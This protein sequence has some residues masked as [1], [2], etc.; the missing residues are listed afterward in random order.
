MG[1]FRISALIDTGASSSLLRED[2]FMAM[3][4]RVRRVH[5]I[6]NTQPLQGIAGVRLP[7]TGCTEVKV[8]KVDSPLPVDIITNMGPE[9]IIGQNWL[10]R[11]KAV[12]DFPAKIVKWFNKEWP[13]LKSYQRGTAIC[14]TRLPCM[15]YPEGDRVIREYADVFSG[16]KDPNGECNLPPMR[17]K[18]VGEPIALPAYRTPLAKRRLVDEAIEEML[19]AGVIRPSSSPWAAPVTLVPKKDGT[20]RFCVDYRR[21]NEVTIKDQFPIP[22]IQ[23]IFDM[24]GGSKIFSSLDLK[25]GYW[26]V[27]VH[28]DD[29]EKSAF[30]CHRG[31]YEFNVMP[32]GLCNAPS[33]FSR[34]MDQALGELIGK[35]VLV[36]IDDLVIF[37]ENKI[38]HARDVGLVLEKLRQ[39]GLKLKPSKCDFAKEEIDLLGYKVG[40]NGISVNPEKVKAIKELE[41]PSAVRHVRSFLGM[42]NYYRQCIPNFAEVAQPLVALTKK[43]ARF[44]WG[45]SQEV[46]FNKLKDLLV[47]SHVMAAP[48]VGQE[49]FLHTDASD[50]TIGGIL[51]QTDDN[52]VERVI[53][54]ISHQLSGSQL[55]WPTIEKECYAIVYCIEKLRPYLYGAEFTVFTDHR[56]LLS[57]FTKQLQNTKIQRWGVLLAEYGAKIQYRQGKYHVRPDMLSR[58][59]HRNKNK[60]VAV[61][62]SDDWVDPQ[63]FPDSNVEEL[64]PLVHDG[65]DLAKVAVHQR[66]EYPDICEQ[67]EKDEGGWEII[68]GVVYSTTRPT[69]AAALYPRL[70]LPKEWQHRVIMRAH[71]DVGHMATGKT[72]ARIS[73]SYIWPGMRGDVKTTLLKCTVCQA[74]SE[75]KEHVPMGEMPI[76]TYPNQ[77]IGMDLI[78]L[79]R[80]P[81]GLK[82]ALTIIDHCSGWAEVYPLPN[83]TNE[84]VWS[85]WT[86][87]YLPAHSVPEVIITDRGQEFCAGPWE[88]YLSQLGVE[89]RKTTPMHPQSNGRTERFNKTFKQLLE[90][91]VN[92]QPTQ[93]PGKIG[94]C[95]TAYRHAVSN[96]TGYSPFYLMYGRHGR[97]PMTKT[98]KQGGGSKFGNR[99]D[100]LSTALQVASEM[101]KNSRIYNRER[102]RQK[103]NAN[104]IEVGDIVVLKADPRV[105]LTSR[106][107]PQWQVTRV[108]GLAIYVRNQLSG[109]CKVVNREKVKLVDPE[110]VWDE[111]NPRPKR[112]QRK[113]RPI[114][115]NTKDQLNQDDPDFTVIHQKDVAQQTLVQQRKITKRHAVPDSAVGDTGGPKRSKALEQ[116]TSADFKTG[117]KPSNEIGTQAHN[118]P[119]TNEYSQSTHHMRLRDCPSRKR[120]LI[121]SPEIQKR[122]RL[123]A[124]C[125][126][127]DFFRQ[128]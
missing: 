52:G 35:C 80:S 33:V 97:L 25:A 92:N 42:A 26:Q 121:P 116:T 11:G 70:L 5:Y 41:T 14:E 127:T 27:K 88:E 2:V 87:Y 17:I 74:H 123:E 99:L 91:A 40:V 64:L 43:H 37:S 96:T 21:L 82:Y 124:I 7:L 93:W 120:H 78:E 90:K 84:S 103:A 85:A 12:I 118:P 49:Y 51:C 56:P 16:E 8:D 47:S 15:G 30:R 72:L 106:W 66:Q 67:A 69:M 3:A 60:E 54:Y 20:T 13:I 31:H 59:E 117:G 34:I 36:Y 63:A 19:K 71:H 68:K 45:E 4:K 102:L 48:R 6:R 44:E 83:K 111:I 29:K 126:V 100:D 107:D 22:N 18:T 128:L 108:N 95:L 125:L 122:A 57:L 81:E 77:V 28:E 65:L 46:A 55:N 89:H 101:T 9:L 10:C 38:D 112:D 53:Q 61:I 50:H 119:D 73:D 76:A 23:E 58:I 32:F 113:R 86:N 114:F 105:K 62:D 75:R 115:H 109:V 104:H 98:L 39:A 110:L 94:A 79:P 24:V 1:G